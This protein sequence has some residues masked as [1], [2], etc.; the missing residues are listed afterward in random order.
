M[1]K[2]REKNYDIVVTFNLFLLPLTMSKVLRY[3]N[4][5]KKKHILFVFLITKSYLCTQVIIILCFHLIIYRL[6][7]I[8][9]S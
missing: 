6:L 4:K 5:M 8:I 1:T 9:S 2:K 7:V 3:G